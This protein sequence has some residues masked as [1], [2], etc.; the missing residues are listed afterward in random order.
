MTHW[1]LKSKDGSL[2]YAQMNETFIETPTYKTSVFSASRWGFK[3]DAVADSSSDS[4]TH[5]HCRQGKINQVWVVKITL[6]PDYE[7]EKG[8]V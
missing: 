4:L 3:E 6:N 7:A 5:K 8:P 2:I 1:C